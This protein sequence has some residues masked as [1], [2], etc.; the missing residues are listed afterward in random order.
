MQT[1]ATDRDIANNGE[2]S[3]S[4]AQESRKLA[5]LF[6]IDPHHGWIT[7]L[8]ELD[9]ETEQSYTLHILAEDNGQHKLSSTAAV[10]INLLDFNDNPP[11]FSQRVY[12]AAV[13][14]GALPGTI[15]FQ[16]QI[17]DKDKEI[18]NKVFAEEK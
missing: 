13:N 15:I 4:F 7:T 17:S 11:T 9:Y 8:G 3:Y 12:T 2:I 6:S 5:H 18:K 10:K 16:L 1:L 14:E